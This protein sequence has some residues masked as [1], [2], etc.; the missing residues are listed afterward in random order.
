MRKIFVMII[1]LQQKNIEDSLNNGKAIVIMGARQ[2]GKTTM[3]MQMF[4]ENED[5]LWLNGDEI[6]VQSVFENVSADRLRGIIGNHKVLVIDEAQRIKD[7]GLRLKLITDKIPEVQLV[8]TGSSSFDLSNKVNEPLTGRKWEF[9]MFPLSFAEMVNHNGLLTEKRMIPHRMVYGYYPEVVTSVGKERDVLRNLADSYLYRDVLSFGMIKKSDKLVALL[10]ALAY[11]VGSQVSY[12]ELAELVGI[13]AK[14]IDSYI[15]ILE[16]SYIVFR[17]QS[18]ARNMR[19]ELKFSKKIYFY[20]NG[21][22]NAIISDFSQVE[23]RADVGALWENFL[24]SERV[25]FAEY[26]KYWANR[27]F[28]RTREQKEIDLLEE[29]D[30][31]LYAYEFKYSASKCPKA[32]LAFRQNYPNATFSVITSDNVESFLLS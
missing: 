4:P 23:N 12:N 3:L 18:Y 9:R 22:R 24:I 6:D 7:I 1:R 32:P 21:L 13:D 5:N 28:W 15:Q 2:T 26:N 29:Y 27:Y 31:K 19:N 17:L 30:G 8:A 10:K 25:K 11:Q 16:K 20:D 14:T